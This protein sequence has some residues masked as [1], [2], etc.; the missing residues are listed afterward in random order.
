[1]PLRQNA[2]CISS[3]H[4][5]SSNSKNFTCHVNI[6]SKMSLVDQEHSTF[7]SRRSLFSRFTNPLSLSHRAR[8]HRVAHMIKPINN[9]YGVRCLDGTFR[10]DKSLSFLLSSELSISFNFSAVA[11]G[12]LYV[13]C[14]WNEWS[15]LHFETTT[16]SRYGRYARVP[17]LKRVEQ[18]ALR[19]RFRGILFSASLWLV[20]FDTSRLLTWALYALVHALLWVLTC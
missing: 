3:Y 17:I 5:V 13:A 18:K 1:M 11:S 8:V 6:P 12:L 4:I 20:E 2:L 16:H 9:C 19:Q 10:C 15:V 7:Q 14:G